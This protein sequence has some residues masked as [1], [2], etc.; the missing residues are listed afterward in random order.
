MEG[1][2]KFY[3]IAIVY[4]CRV[5]FVSYMCRT[6]SFCDYFK[7]LETAVDIMIKKG[8]GLMYGVVVL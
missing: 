2:F 4:S 7:C 5:C 8:Y 6:F 3:V 1:I